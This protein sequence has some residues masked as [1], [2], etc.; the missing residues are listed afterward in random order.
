MNRRNFLKTAAGISIATAIPTIATAATDP[1]SRKSKRLAREQLKQQARTGYPLNIYLHEK[2]LNRVMVQWAPWPT[3]YFTLWAP[4]AFMFGDGKNFVIKEPVNWKSDGP[5]LRI[6][7]ADV[8]Y[9]GFSIRWQ[10]RLAPQT[11]GVNFQISVTNTGQNPLRPQFSINSC[12]NFIYAPDFMD[13]TGDFT[14]FRTRGRWQ[15]MT[16]LRRPHAKI[17]GHDPYNFPVKGYC[18]NKNV[19]ADAEPPVLPALS[20][21]EGSEAEGVRRIC[22]DS[23]LVVRVGRT[24]QYCIG[25]A[26][27]KAVRLDINFNRLHCIHSVPA[28]GPLAPGKSVTRN[29]KFYFHKGSKDDLL[30][31]VN[32][33]I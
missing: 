19:A 9:G 2:D 10:A 6:E 4:E 13:S 33:G 12:F 7:P 26:W 3:D 21:A 11:D 15:S 16:S 31:M 20:E 22:A 32:A 14:F 27:D 18:E 5:D 29:G 1:P 24:R 25:Y 23:S 17:Y 8:S 28:L 30:K